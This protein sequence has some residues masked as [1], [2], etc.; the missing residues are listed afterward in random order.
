MMTVIALIGRPEV[1]GAI[2]IALGICLI[3]HQH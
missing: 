1:L 2:Y 3:F